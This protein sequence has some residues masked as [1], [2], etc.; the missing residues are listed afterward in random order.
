MDWFILVLCII[1]GAMFVRMIYED[2]RYL[3]I[4]QYYILFTL[5]IALIIWYTFAIHTFWFL[6]IYF[7]ITVVVGIVLHK[8]KLVGASDTKLVAVTLPIVIVF[9]V[10]MPLA[11]IINLVA[12]GSVYLGMVYIKKKIQNKTQGRVPFIHIVIISLLFTVIT[13]TSV[14]YHYF[15]FT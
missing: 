14:L 5:V 2:Y 13:Q 15:T 10:Y 6:A 8:Y 7:I 4:P 11:Y 3:Q 1:L 12:F 9:G